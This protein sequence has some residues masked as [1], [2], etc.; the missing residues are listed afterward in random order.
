MV[1]PDQDVSAALN[2]LRHALT[3]YKKNNYARHPTTVCLPPDKHAF[4]A[5]QMCSVDW[6]FTRWDLH[7]KD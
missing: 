5:R 1:S 2:Q 6:N 4:V 3:E 7:L